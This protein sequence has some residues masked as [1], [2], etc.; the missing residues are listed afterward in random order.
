[1]FDGF[2]IQMI[3][4]SA[5]RTALKSLKY[6]VPIGLAAATI[7]GSIEY[8]LTGNAGRS[9]ELARD[10]FLVPAVAFP[11]VVYQCETFDEDYSFL[12]RTDKK[13]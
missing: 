11:I 1:M 9:L 7:I 12:F 10:V 2:S 13:S 4:M 3:V 8:A 5:F 6:S